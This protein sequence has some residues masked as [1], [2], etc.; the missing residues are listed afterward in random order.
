MRGDLKPSRRLRTAAP[1]FDAFEVLH[2]LLA[3]AVVASVV[4]TLALRLS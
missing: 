3:T 2:L 4:A 1:A